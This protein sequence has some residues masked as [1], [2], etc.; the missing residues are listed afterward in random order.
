MPNLFV[1]LVLFIGLFVGNKIGVVSGLFIGIILDA[2]F[3]RI[4]GVTGVILAIIGYAG[5]YF[6][7]NFSKDNRIMILAI[8]A[9]GTIFFEVAMYIIKYIQFKP[10]IELQAF[11]VKLALEIIF[12]LLIITTIYPW[13][14]K[15]GYH[16]EDIF[17]GRKL[18]TRYF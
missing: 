6:D 3:G 17:K 12:N 5:E 7:K 1:V 18:L 9:V 2:S 10:E 4:I 15:L 13:M 8:S 16:L 11:G 14:K